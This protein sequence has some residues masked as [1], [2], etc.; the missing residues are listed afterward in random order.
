MT[1]FID[2]FR[3]DRTI[4]PCQFGAIYAVEDTASNI[5]YAAKVISNF[6]VKEKSLRGVEDPFNEVDILKRIENRPH[7]NLISSVMVLATEQSTIAVLPLATADLCEH[8]PKTLEEA[9]LV[10]HQ[11][12]SGLS[13][14]HDIIGVEHGDLSLENVAWF[15]NKSVKIIDYGQAVPIGSV[16]GYSNVRGKVL[17]SA[18]ELALGGIVTGACDVFSLGVIMFAL[19]TGQMPFENATFRDHWYNALQVHGLLSSKTGWDHSER[20]TSEFCELF[21]GMTKHDVADRWTL[22]RVAAHA[23]VL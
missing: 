22:Q 14:L 7:R 16:R 17:Y 19:V 15:E 9:K 13:F 3:I 2:R 6:A 12:L 20:L 4:Y 18:P 8:P 1:N 21:E 10:F 5:M 23:W 11:L